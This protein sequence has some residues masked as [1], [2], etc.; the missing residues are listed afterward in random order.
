[1][2]T[3]ETWVPELSGTESLAVWAENSSSLGLSHEV[4]HGRKTQALQGSFIPS[5]VEITA[6][7]QF[8]TGCVKMRSDK[9]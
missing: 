7:A 3:E 1:M 6:R 8:H 9:G 2:E 4:T 5:K